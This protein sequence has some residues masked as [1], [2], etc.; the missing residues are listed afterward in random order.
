[1]VCIIYVYIYTQL[2]KTTA[3]APWPAGTDISPR[4]L[5]SS[6]P[7]HPAPGWSPVPVVHPPLLLFQDVIFL[8]L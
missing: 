1:M 5:S 2:I 4:H 3:L 8:V 7:P 6:A